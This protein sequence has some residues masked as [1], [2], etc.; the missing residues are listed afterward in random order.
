[1]TRNSPSQMTP[2]YLSIY[3]FQQCRLPG[4][5]GSH[6][7]HSR[8]QVN[9][10][11]KV[12]VYPWSLGGVAEAD[13]LYHDHWGWDL[14]TVRERERDD[15]GARSKKSE[16]EGDM[17]VHNMYEPSTSWLQCQVMLH[18]VNH[19]AGHVSRQYQASWHH[20]HSDKGTKTKIGILANF[21]P[22][23]THTIRGYM[24]C[25]CFIEVYFYLD[26]YQL[27]IRWRRRC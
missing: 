7:R 18:R 14:T 26:N 15:L 3:Q 8:L 6:Q 10:K 9:P 22:P 19:C 23:M 13:T 25:W 21:W 27:V 12:L 11:I 20:N 2:S 17:E 1:M 24:I 4:S 5:V 16:R